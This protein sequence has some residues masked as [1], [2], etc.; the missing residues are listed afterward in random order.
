MKAYPEDKNGL[1]DWVGD[2]PKH[3]KM[4]QL[5]FAAPR[6]TSKSTNHG[7]IDF[8]VALENI[9]S[10]TGRLIGSGAF[11]GIGNAF[12]KDDVLYNKLRPYLNKGFLADKNGV[13]VGELLVL[14]PSVEIDGKFLLYRILENG[15]MSIVDGSTYGAKMPRASW[16]FIGDLKIPV[17]PFPEQSAIADFLDRKT[18]QIDALIAKKQRQIELLQENR[19][20]LINQAVT[21][22]PNPDAP[23][24]DSGIEWLGEVPAHWEVKRIKHLLKPTKSAIKTGPFGSQLKNSDMMGS[25]IKVYNQRSVI[26]V[27]F[28]SGEYYISHQKFKQLKEFEI[29]PGD[30]LITTRGTIG[31]CAIF[32]DEAERGVL[33]PCLI[34]LQLDEEIML[35]EYLIWF[36]Q[37]SV[38]FQESIFYESNATTIDVIYSGTLKQVI[39]PIPPLFEQK[40]IVDF[41]RAKGSQI[42]EGIKRIEEQIDLLQDYRTALISAAVTGK[43]DV[44]GD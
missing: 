10:H 26:D 19:A 4:V 17:P 27:N 20:A 39:V 31:R 36:I 8:H 9:E 16:D 33:H 37:D 28:S 34:R 25:D 2:I 14:R 21:K 5:K 13:A 23:M 15:F 40:A 18:A 7:S 3:W 35:K 24:K 1:Y 12:Q 42:S 32:P 41:L 29:F 11:D 38:L 22:G 6:V 44:R 30:I 43:I